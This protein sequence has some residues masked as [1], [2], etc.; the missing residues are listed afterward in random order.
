MNIK[1]LIILLATL[2]FLLSA[3]SSPSAQ[4]PNID[5]TDG[6]IT[7][8]FSMSTIQEERWTKDRDIFVARARQLGANVIVQNADN[9][10]EEQLKQVE[11]LIQQKINVLV[12]IPQSATQAAQAVELAK[13][14]NI[15]VISYDRLVLNANTDVYI[16]F[17]NHAVGW[18]MA[19]EA[20]KKVPK[21]N[22]LLVNG[23][24]EDNNSDM[25]KSGYV[26]YLQPYIDR[27][28]IK[29][30]GQTSAK[31]WRR[32]E[33]Y[34]FVQSKL[35]E[36]TKID[37]IICAN[38]SLAG[39][40]IQA[41]AEARQAGKVVVTGH[42]ADLAG[43]QRIVEGTQA[44]T[45]YKPIKNIAQKAAEV[46][47]QMAKGEKFESNDHINDGKYDIPYIKLDVIAVTKENMD[48]VITDGFHLKEDIYKN[49]TSSSSTPSAAP[50]ITPSS[51][52][53]PTTS[54]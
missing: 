26:D 28:D 14:A 23:S 44:V 49:I 48:K 54:P 24:P 36:G 1:K 13:R 17:D 22:Y 39:G 37:A 31:D 51:T 45:V 30:V 43:C 32:E 27:G 12:L 9:D 15:P 2:V 42:D 8:G 52:A 5:K 47:I 21:G 41:L 16:S 7:I 34:N 20:V 6:S 25:F 3:C 4:A 40:T 18:K 33:A 11:Y 35:L 29:I 53:G 46:A 10:P 50:S 19:E 38:D